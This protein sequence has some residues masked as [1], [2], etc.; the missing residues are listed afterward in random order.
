MQHRAPL[1]P[2]PQN[3][4]SPSSATSSNAPS[5]P[6]PR[7]HT[8]SAKR[9]PKLAPIFLSKRVR[10]GRESQENIAPGVPAKKRLHLAG[11]SSIPTLSDGS[12]AAP[13]ESN[14]EDDSQGS[15]DQSDSDDDHQLYT[16]RKSQS[17]HDYFLPSTSRYGRVKDERQDKENTRV[18]EPVTKEEGVWKR[19][20]R[21]LGAKGQGSSLESQ[22]L[23]PP[24]QAYL[25]TLLHSLLPYH[26][27]RPPASIL[28]PSIH[29]PT[30]RPRDFAPPLAVSFNHIAKQYTSSDA[31]SQGLRRLIGIAG[32][33]GGVRIL[34]VDE[35][36][37]MHREEKGWWWRAHGNAIFDLKWS[38]DDTKVLTASG[39]QTSRLHALTT[40]TPTLLA[41]L[42]GHTSSVKTVT[43]L[44]PC[45][46]ANNPSQSS[47]IASGGRDGNIL[48]YDVRTKG[49]D[50]ELGEYG[51]APMRREGSRE[52]YRDGIPG[53]APQTS[54]EVLDP[55]MVIKGA[56]GDGKRSARTATRSVTSLLALSSI[57]G[58]LASGGSFDGIIKLW[59][60][61]FPAPTNRSSNP[62]P[63]C[64]PS[65]SLPDATL[66]GESPAKRARSINAMVESPVTGDVYALCGDSKIHVLR[67]SAALIRH[68]PAHSSGAVSAFAE[69][70]TYAEAVQP[71]T[72]S[73]PSMLISNFYIRLSLS[74][75]GRY[76]AAGSCKGGL[77][78]W[79]TQERGQDMNARRGASRTVAKKLGMGV[80]VRMSGVGEKD[81]EVCAVEWGKDILAATSDGSLTRIW[82]SEP[83]I[84]KQI[85]G[86]PGAYADEWAGAI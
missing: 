22:C 35:G 48:I 72:Y 25:S 83:E 4:S 23:I 33:E 62:R 77:M 6:T 66:S 75:D 76:L 24:P 14:G 5:T 8:F 54:G 3:L 68:H 39:D 60:L 15:D 85:A 36:L 50:P 38:T 52:R 70:E 17:I 74:P 12:R 10:G 20:R 18:I 69:E 84:A 42:R 58:T 1:T 57:P 16:Q 29:P 71:A 37:G 34:D 78:T 81:R 11:P 61:R 67:P 59:D 40:P 7:R 32:E 30:G 45:R 13:I 55:V 28:L 27:L 2:I 41:T 86:N 47:V 73:D 43:F 31:R 21:R 9:P 56:H 49:R 80:E 64:T 46:S 51:T 44:D 26:P 53:F 65:G 63:T 82:R 79:D 19:K